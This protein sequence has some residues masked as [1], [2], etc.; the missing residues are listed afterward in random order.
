MKFFYVMPF[1]LLLA[2]GEAHATSV[3]GT[4]AGQIYYS[5]NNDPLG[6]V[7]HASGYVTGPEVSV[8]FAFD[9]SNVDAPTIYDLGNGKSQYDFTGS[10]LTMAATVDGTTYSIGTASL[11]GFTRN[12]GSPEYII[13]GFSDSGSIS[14]DAAATVT[15][16]TDYTTLAQNFSLSSADGTLSP[17]SLMDLQFGGGPNSTSLNPYPGD[18]F[19]A[20]VTSFTITDTGSGGDA[21]STDVPEP[22]SAALLAGALALLRAHRRRGSRS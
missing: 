3:S 4:F 17:S 14:V 18:E 13:G 7:G 16:F 20:T 9:T 10:G 6:I 1:F 8:S 11:Q 5:Y 22:A 15:A 2:A 21:G 12:L 19:L